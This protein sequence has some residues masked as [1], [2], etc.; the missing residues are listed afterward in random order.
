LGDIAPS[1]FSIITKIGR[2]PLGYKWHQWICHSVDASLKKLRR[3]R[4]NGLIIHNCD[5]LVREDVIEICKVLNDMRSKGLITSGGFSL[6]TIDDGFL[7]CDSALGEFQLAQ[8]PCN[9]FDDRFEK[10]GIVDALKS[11]DTQ[12]HARSIFLQGLLLMD[13]KDLNPYFL[14]WKPNLLRLSNLAKINNLNKLDICVSYIK[15]KKYLDGVIVGVSN[16]NELVDIAE[17][18]NKYH[19]IDL[20]DLSCDDLNLIVP[21]N[22]AI[23]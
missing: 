2:K 17:S 11:S 6:N 4:L 13:I 22:W 9:I 18:F 5:S 8:V 19:P 14:K 10:S 20:Y 12:I 7:V 23:K 21:S 1:V 3:K 16:L 15:K